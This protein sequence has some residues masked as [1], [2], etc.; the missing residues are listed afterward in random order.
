MYDRR[1]VINDNISHFFQIS[2][3]VI[4]YF[5]FLSIFYFYVVVQFEK[6][7]LNN[8]IKII[9]DTIIH[10]IKT[11]MSGIVPDLNTMDVD[12]LKVLL[13]GEID[14]TEQQG[15][16]SSINA[17]KKIADMNDNL[18]R[19]TF[20]IV[21]VA[22]IILVIMFIFAACYRSVIVSNIK[23]STIVIIFLSIVEVCVLLFVINK[24]ISSNPKA[25]EHQIALSV[26]NWI[27]KNKNLSQ[28]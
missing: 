7:N 15:N 4:L 2:I 14:L 19:S 25:I 12:S 6:N 28:H 5:I 23:E 20:T 9:V 27:Q 11:N 21:I 24:Y 16:K 3:Q 17:N 18:R 22:I 1:C 8:Q 10:D 13:F 26:K